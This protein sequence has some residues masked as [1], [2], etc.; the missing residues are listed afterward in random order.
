MSPFIAEAA[1][2]V[3]DYLRAHGATSAEDLT[4]AAIEAGLPAGNGRRFGPVLQTLRHYGEI[5]VVGLVRR[6]NGHHSL[7]RVW[8]LD[9]E[10]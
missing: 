2:F 10:G 7:G 3:L 5:R 1:G 4:A 6:R 9:L 8:D